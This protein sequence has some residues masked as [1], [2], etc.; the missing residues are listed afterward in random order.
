MKMPSLN[1]YGK[2]F[3]CHLQRSIL[4]TFLE[5]FQPD[6]LKA[7]GSEKKLYTYLAPKPK[8]SLKAIEGVNKMVSYSLNRK[9]STHYMV[10]L[11]SYIRIS[12]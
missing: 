11:L 2:L 12:Q 9:F 6:C 7:I 8:S 4:K 1:R 5:I 10:L 3:K